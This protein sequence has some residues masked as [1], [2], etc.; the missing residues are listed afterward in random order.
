MKTNTFSLILTLLAISF[1]TKFVLCQNVSTMD[2]WQNGTG[3]HKNY[4]IPSLLVTKNGTLLA[5]CEGREGGD[6]GDIDLLL[7]IST[8]NGVTWNHE[9]VVWNDGRNTCG[10]PCPVVDKE[11]GRI[12][13]FMTWNLGSDVEKRIIRKESQDTRRPFVCY[14][15]DDGVSWSKPVDLSKTCKDPSWGWYATGPGVGIQLQRGKY[16]GR[17]VIP[18]NHSYDDPSGKIAGGPFGYGSHVLISD[19]YGKTWK[20]SEPIRPGC[21]ESQV[22]ELSDGSLLMNMRSYNDNHCRA[23]STSEDGGETWS[24]IRPDRQLVESRCQASLIRY[25]TFDNKNMFLFSNPAVPYGRTHMTIKT[26]FDD[27]KTWSN[28]KLIHPGPSAYSCM[29]KLPNGKIGLLFEYG[30]EHRY[31]KIRFVSFSPEMLFTPGTLIH[32]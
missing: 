25:G 24:A 13:L 23:I 30:T 17:L 7:K 4:R 22:I 16:R 18:A 32:E 31:D 19:D 8:D 12:W 15:D 1:P 11:S 27:C 10:N 5:F 21:N 29:A 9:T 28:A 2:L 20:M 26:S 14:S 6:S 3:I